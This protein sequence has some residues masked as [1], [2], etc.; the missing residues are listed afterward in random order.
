MPASCDIQDRTQLIQDGSR[1]TYKLVFH[2][3]TD[4]VSESVVSYERGNRSDDAKSTDNRAQTNPE[5]LYTNEKKLAMFES[6]V[7][8]V[9]GQEECGVS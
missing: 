3:K 7:S 6:R 1:S 2:E 9:S 4:H 5:E 8:G